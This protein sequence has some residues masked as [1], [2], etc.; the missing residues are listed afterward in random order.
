MPF[1]VRNLVASSEVRLP[2]S[3]TVDVWQFRLDAL[4]VGE[5][6]WQAALRDDERE[7]AARYR[8]AAK[9]HE[10][11]AA[12]GILRL[13][14]G[15]CLGCEPQAPDIVPDADG[16]P[17][18]PGIEFNVSH[19][20]AGCLISLARQP[21]GVDIEVVQPR[22]TAAG[23][24]ERY[25][26]EAE[27]R[28][29]AALPESVRPA[30]FLRGWTC[31]EAVLKADGRGARGLEICAVNL[32]PHALPGV[33][34]FDGQDWN[35]V[36]WEPWPGTVAAAAAVGVALAGGHSDNPPPIPGTRRF[37]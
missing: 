27:K 22:P 30:A 33:V 36:A 14:L 26:A 25:F 4:P 31:K 11:A 2:P 13:L 8:A 23:L 12:R 20:R 32:D 21:V 7:R 17:H 19:C 28:Q 24:V 6:A 18:T 34:E 5:A 35:L 37:P 29:F 9:G 16:K 10:F 15:R 1:C 3:G